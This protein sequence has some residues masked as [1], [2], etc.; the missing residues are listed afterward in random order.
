[1]FRRTKN[2]VAPI[3]ATEPPNTNDGPRRSSKTVHS[4][5]ARELAGFP[6]DLIAIMMTVAGKIPV[7]VS[8]RVG[9]PPPLDLTFPLCTKPMSVKANTC[10]FGPCKGTLPERQEIFGRHHSV[11]LPENSAFVDFPIVLEKLLELIDEGALAF[12]GVQI[13]EGMGYLVFR[14][15]DGQLPKGF[16]R[17]VEKKGK[18]ILEIDSSQSQLLYFYPLNDEII[19]KIEI[20]EDLSRKLNPWKTPKTF[21][22][23]SWWEENWGNFE[24]LL[25]RAVPLYFQDLAHDVPIQKLRVLSVDGAIM[26][27]DCDVMAV[28]PSQRFLNKLPHYPILDLETGKPVENLTQLLLEP[29]DVSRDLFRMIY[30]LH[31]LD[32]AL[33]LFSIHKN[34]LLLEDFRRRNIRDVTDVISELNHLHREYKRLSIMT[35][36]EVLSPFMNTELMHNVFDRITGILNPFELKFNSEVNKHF[37]EIGCHI[38]QFLHHGPENRNPGK[39]SDIGPIMHIIGAESF[40]TMTEAR[41]VKFIM[42]RLMDESPGAYFIDIHPHWSM[43]KWAGVVQRQIDLGMETFIRPSTMDAYQVYMASKRSGFM[44]CLFSTCRKDRPVFPPSELVVQSGRVS[45]ASAQVS[46]DYAQVPFDYAQG[47]HRF[48]LDAV[49]EEDPSSLEL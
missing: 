16:G 46:F 9:N 2:K 40:V 49:I 17:Y 21:N 29:L 37:R 18:T 25:V 3:G 34:E 42:D 24:E 6:T 31:Y 45:L 48:T 47:D 33:I 5:T 26:V 41:Y 22:R 39:P 20:T 12:E 10:G 35:I 23:P 4:A 30:R 32:Q 43:E 7:A 38:G 13:I 8:L 1:M 36:E 15:L 14:P 11:P 44:G 28:M 27:G 19:P